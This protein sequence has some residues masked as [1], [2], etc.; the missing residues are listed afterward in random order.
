MK[1]EF[2]LSSQDWGE[3]WGPR[4]CEYIAS[5]K[6][7][8]TE[9]KLFYVKVSPPLPKALGGCVD[10]VG[11]I[12]LGT[13]S[14]DWTLKDIGKFGFIVDIYITTVAIK[15]T[16]IDVTDL[17]RV[18]VGKIYKTYQDAVLDGN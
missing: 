2:F 10:N 9:Q 6:A 7:K 11:R 1:E 5:Y 12:L 16:T 17:I 14:N 4:K 8:P 18:G 3:P 13:I 15:V